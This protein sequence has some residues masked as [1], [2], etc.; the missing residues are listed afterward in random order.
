MPSH[1]PSNF[2][3]IYTF[4][5]FSIFFRGVFCNFHQVFL[6]FRQRKSNFDIVNNKIYLN[7]QASIYKFYKLKLK[8]AAV[9]VN[10][11]SLMV[12]FS[13]MRDCGSIPHGDST[14]ST[15]S[16]IFFNNNFFKKV[17]RFFHFQLMLVIRRQSFCKF[18]KGAQVIFTIFVCANTLIT[19]IIHLI[20][21]DNRG[22]KQ[23][24]L[25]IY[26]KKHFLAV[27]FYNR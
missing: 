17:S 4:L 22:Y 10:L 27:T 13:F 26:A 12:R 18:N 15:F 20:T 2:A 11:H 8:T 21:L 14:V 9:G 24:F 3:P 16:S 5:K 19:I 23:T 6:F 7:N 25:A 1:H